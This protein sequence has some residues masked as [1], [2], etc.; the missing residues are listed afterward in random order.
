MSAIVA[1]A[2]LAIKLMTGCN[3]D[4][5]SPGAQENVASAEQALAATSYSGRG[6]AVAASILGI[7]TR[8]SD[9]GPLPSAGGSFG[10]SLI[11]AN[12]PGLLSS[13]TL[14]AWVNGAGLQSV[15]SA[16]VEKLSVKLLGLGLSATIVGASATAQCTSAGGA[17]SG[18][19]VVASLVINGSSVV[20]TGLP[21][22][23]INVPLVAKIVINEQVAS[24]SASGA[25]IDVSAIHITLLRGLTDV[26]IAAAQAGIAC[27]PISSTS[28]STS[29]GVGAGASTG[30]G[31]GAST[32]TG[33][34][35]STGASTGTGCSTET[36]TS[37]SIRTSAAD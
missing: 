34:G 22:Q 3:G 18:Q 24:A 23:I 5:D 10:G 4:Q 27:A 11:T 29:T 9:T 20:V 21:N 19:S 36:S 26:R 16:S 6:V 31:A 35:A 15:T 2:G 17:A 30:V 37:S 1:G 8:L 32:G 14:N 7:P 25:D 12:I 33:A 28:T 13:G